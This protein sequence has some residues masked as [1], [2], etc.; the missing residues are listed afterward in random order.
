MRRAGENEFKRLEQV[1]RASEENE[2]S[3]GE[4]RR[5]V[6]EI[7]VKDERARA[8]L[9][10]K[11]DV[12][13]QGSLPQ[14]MRLMLEKR[15]IEILKKHSV[16]MSIEGEHKRYE[17]YEPIPEPDAR[18]HTYRVRSGE[19]RPGEACDPRH[20]GSSCPGGRRGGL[21]GRPPQGLVG[22]HQ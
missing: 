13:V 14:R 11:F 16:P 19:A 10:D 21:P 2:Y 12:E 22:R 7:D 9:K 8:L 18:R 1:E 5:Y 4:D 6:V 17:G 20:R 15:E 3:P